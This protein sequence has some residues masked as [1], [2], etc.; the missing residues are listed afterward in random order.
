MS[1]RK[2]F[3]SWKVEMVYR[4]QD[5]VCGNEDCNRSLSSGFHRH[6][7]DGDSS[8]NEIDNLQLLCMRCHGGEQYETLMKKKE[9]F[10]QH[11]TDFLDM[12][13]T[14]KLS[15]SLADQLKDLIKLGLSLSWQLYGDDIEKPPAAI[16]MEEQLIASGILTKQ[17]EEGMRMGFNKGLAANINSIVPILENT[18]RDKQMIAGLKMKLEAIKNAVKKKSN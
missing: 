13:K 5:G 6:H 14:G 11:T 4:L 18:I 7:K 12:A 2:D 15:G 9:L 16:R 10:L 17:Y 8:N 3:K 1:E